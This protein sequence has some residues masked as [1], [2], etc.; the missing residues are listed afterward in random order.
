MDDEREQQNEHRRKE[1]E[2]RPRQD[3]QHR[4]YRGGRE[5]AAIPA[6]KGCQHERDEKGFGQADDGEKDHWRITGG[7]R[8]REYPGVRVGKSSSVNA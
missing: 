3:G 6:K 2:D 8:T 4:E 1:I 7:G 5:P